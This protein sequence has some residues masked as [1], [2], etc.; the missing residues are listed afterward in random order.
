MTHTH[1]HNYSHTHIHNIHNIHNIHT[2]YTMDRFQQRDF[3]VTRIQK[4][5][6][7]FLVRK[8]IEMD[9]EPWY[10]D[11][12]IDLP[13]SGG[14]ENILK[15]FTLVEYDSEELLEEASVEELL[16]AL[17]KVHFRLPRHKARYLLKIIKKRTNILSMS[18]LWSVM[19]QGPAP[20]QRL[21]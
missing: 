9:T 4:V 2:A 5:L 20:G 13:S 19:K 7:G 3:F 15:Q 10:S 11:L 16:E 1:T 6:R 21:T 14:W 18:C 12:L 8:K 17:E